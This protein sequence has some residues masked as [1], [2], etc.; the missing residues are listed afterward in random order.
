MQNLGPSPRG[1]ES[2]SAFNW[3]LSASCIVEFECG[4]RMACFRRECS[5]GLS[6]GLV[7][8][9]S[10]RWITPPPHSDLR[11]HHCG[12][13]VPASHNTSLWSPVPDSHQSPSMRGSAWIL[14]VLSFLVNAAFIPPHSQ[15]SSFGIYLCALAFIS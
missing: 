4:G 10:N 8:V 2:E 12:R 9:L 3:T 1:T 5:H 7:Q 15:P 6:T 14:G 13:P 11:M